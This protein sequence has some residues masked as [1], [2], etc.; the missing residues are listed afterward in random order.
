M[1]ARRAA[2]E[3]APRDEDAGVAV[4]GR[5]Q[6]EGRI[7]LARSRVPPIVEEE[8]PEARALN[9]LEKLLGDDLIGVHV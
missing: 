3:V 9:P 6:H 4:A 1:L 7:R 8:L 2:A 5:V